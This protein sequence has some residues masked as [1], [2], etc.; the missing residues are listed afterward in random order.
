LK[1]L[2]LSPEDLKSRPASPAGVLQRLERLADTANLPPG[3]DRQQLG[4][5]IKL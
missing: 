2:L 4:T 3:L 1:D 5:P